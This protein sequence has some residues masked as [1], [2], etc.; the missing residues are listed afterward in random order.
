MAGCLHC[1]TWRLLWNFLW[2]SHNELS[3][4]KNLEDS[5][6]FLLP[7]ELH[8]HFFEDLDSFN[9]NLSSTLL[10]KRKIL[11]NNTVLKLLKVP[12]NQ[13]LK[14]MIYIFLQII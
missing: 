10:N 1:I 11:K 7:K 12:K 8:K 4:L 14:M 6:N 2:K 9:N 13:N 5:P 3:L